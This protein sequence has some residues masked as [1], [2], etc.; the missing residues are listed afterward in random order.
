MKQYYKKKSDIIG[1][2]GCIVLMVT[3]FFFSF[4]AIQNLKELIVCTAIVAGTQGMW[5]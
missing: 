1:S 5:L 3:A 4:K 2:Y